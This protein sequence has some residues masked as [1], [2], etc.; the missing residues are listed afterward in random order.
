MEN[1]KYNGWTNYATWRINLEIFDGSSL[2]DI[3]ANSSWSASD[4]SDYLK[5]YV[6]NILQESSEGIA[7]DY[8][9]A[10]ISDVNWYEIAEHLVENDNE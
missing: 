8:A 6:Y 7:L 9:F 10:F 4:L 5:D 3:G 2:D 1:Q